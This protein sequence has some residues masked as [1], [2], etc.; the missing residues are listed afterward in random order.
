MAIEELL[1]E[2]ESKIS[3]IKKRFYALNAIV[4]ETKRVTGGKNFRIRND[5]IWDM[6]FDSFQMLIIDLA[7]FC[8]GMCEGNR[9]GV[10][11]CVKT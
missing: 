11:G 7:S 10:S 6:V 9:T 8:K 1:K 2:Y 5:I 4:D 3:T